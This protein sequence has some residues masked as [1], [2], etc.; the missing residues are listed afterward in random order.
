MQDVWECVNAL[1]REQT[2]CRYFESRVALGICLALSPTTRGTSAA[3]L[4]RALRWPIF[5][6][7]LGALI[8]AHFA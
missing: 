7:A 4:C 8:A 3:W 5:N 1:G 2:A 6:L